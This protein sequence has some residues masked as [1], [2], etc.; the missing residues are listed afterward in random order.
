MIAEK[1]KPHGLRVGY[2]NNGFDFI[3]IA[4]KTKWHI[5]ADNTSRD[6]ILQLDTGNAATAG[7][8]V[9]VVEL[10]NRYPG[11]TISIHIKPFSSKNH[12]A[13]LGEDE[14]DWPEIFDTCENTGG[15]EWYIIEYEKEG[16]P[17][18]QAMKMNLEN[19]RKLL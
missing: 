4:G 15:T 14:L 9:D 12:K 16:I 2:H 10:I 6:V 19:M 1:L 5:L 11:R 18:L 17:P 8:Y 13:L 7:R 3:T